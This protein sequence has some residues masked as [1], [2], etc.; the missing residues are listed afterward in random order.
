MKRP[1]VARRAVRCVSALIKKHNPA[2]NRDQA[3]FGKVNSSSDRLPKVSIVQTA[4]QA[5]AK[6]TNP[7]PQEK[8]RDDVVPNPA[9]EKMVE[10]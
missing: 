10:E 5:N 2:V 6:L 1:V 8:S 3:M 7:K 4:G 9:W